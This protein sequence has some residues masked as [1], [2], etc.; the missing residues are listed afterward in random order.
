MVPASELVTDQWD[1]TAAFL[2]ADIDREVYMDQP[3]GFIKPGE[4]H[5]NAAPTRTLFPKQLTKAARAKSNELT[6]YLKKASSAAEPEV[7]KAC[8]QKIDDLCAEI[9]AI[10]RGH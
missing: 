1:C 5:L 9:A 8:V 3:P 2:H 6:Q 10:G 4:E 7:R